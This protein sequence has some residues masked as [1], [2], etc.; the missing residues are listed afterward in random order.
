[1]ACRRRALPCGAPAAPLTTASQDG[2]LT[3]VQRAYTL[4]R[5]QLAPNP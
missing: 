1:M 4:S 2:D 5:A 3:I